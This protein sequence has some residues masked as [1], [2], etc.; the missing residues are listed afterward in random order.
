[1]EAEAF[2]LTIISKQFEQETSLH[3]CVEGWFLVQFFFSAPAP[4]WSLSSP[5]HNAESARLPS[6]IFPVELNALNRIALGGAHCEKD[7]F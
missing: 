4:V 1:V 5:R 2:A 6:V 3:K 7:C